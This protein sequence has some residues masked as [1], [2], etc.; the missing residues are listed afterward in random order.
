MRRER[1]RDLTAANLTH[2]FWND[3]AGPERLDAR[4]QLNHA[5]G[6]EDGEGP[7]AA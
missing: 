7:E 5:L 3:V 2:A 4:S 1:E 6:R